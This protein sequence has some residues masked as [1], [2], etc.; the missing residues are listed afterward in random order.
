MQ[1]P[2]EMLQGQ[3]CPWQNNLD[4]LAGTYT[5]LMPDAQL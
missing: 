2:H 3:D 1:K 4:M 5:E